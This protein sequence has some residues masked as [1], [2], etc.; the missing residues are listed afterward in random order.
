MQLDLQRKPYEALRVRS[1]GKCWSPSDIENKFERAKRRRNMSEQRVGC[2]RDWADERWCVRQ[3][4]SD[5]RC[6][7]R[8]RM[9][10]EGRVE[11]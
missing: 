7:R 1:G 9:N 4:T 2:A 11:G 6:D 3:W 10:V 8:Q 5:W